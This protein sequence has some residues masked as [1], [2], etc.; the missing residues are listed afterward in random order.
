MKFSHR[1]AAMYNIHGRWPVQK[2]SDANSAQN[3]IAAGNGRRGQNGDG[4]SDDES[5]T[6]QHGRSP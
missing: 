5:K 1:F 4:G 3:H 6:N 2:A